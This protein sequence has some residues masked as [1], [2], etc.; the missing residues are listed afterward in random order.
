MEVVLSDVPLVIHLTQMPPPVNNLY[1]SAGKRRIKSER[2][3]RWLEQM[4]WEI[5]APG[6]IMPAR[7]R[8]AGKV[9][10]TVDV[11]RPFTS[12]GKIIKSDIDGRL[13]A[14]LDLLV[15]MDLID[16]DSGVD[17]VRARWRMEPGCT[18]TVT[19]HEAQI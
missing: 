13:K 11:G 4:G 14:A 19:R 18:I 15:M 12:T 2:Y 9:A 17:D 10:V 1:V 3:R 6:G 8:I 7:D 16:D 5:K